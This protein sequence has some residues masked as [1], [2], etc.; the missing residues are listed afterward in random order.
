MS[1]RGRPRIL[2]DE[3]KQRAVCALISVGAGYEAAARHVGCSTWTIRREAQRDE[4]FAR[5]LRDAESAADMIPLQ[6]LR[7]AAQTH[8]R[9][10]AW[11]L[12]RISPDRFARPQAKSLSLDRVSTLLRDV[13]DIVYEDCDDP[14]Q[15]GRAS[16]KLEALHLQYCG[17]AKVARQSPVRPLSALDRFLQDIDQA[18]EQRFQE[19]AGGVEGLL[20]DNRNAL[21]AKAG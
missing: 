15:I 6:M 16:Q 21:I 8:W 2:D 17:E 13:A 4:D 1:N 20:S 14:E 5:R 12:E 7:K 10:A 19:F 3:Q 11:L 18:E 9:A